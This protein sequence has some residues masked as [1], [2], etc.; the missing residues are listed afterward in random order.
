MTS[1]PSVHRCVSVV[2][3]FGFATDND[4]LIDEATIVAS[5]VSVRSQSA[6]AKKTVPS[7]ATNKTF[8]GNDHLI[9][10]SPGHCN[11]IVVG[12]HSLNGL[13]PK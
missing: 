4:D 6:F 3:L 7:G 11:T 9:T 10:I 5:I 2:D 8:P 13:F 12:F 1:L